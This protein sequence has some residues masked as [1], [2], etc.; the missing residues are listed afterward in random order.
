MKAMPTKWI[1]YL[2]AVVGA[3]VV[4]A[5]VVGGAVSGVCAAKITRSIENSQIKC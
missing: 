2:P 4:G 1:W 3:A 5:G